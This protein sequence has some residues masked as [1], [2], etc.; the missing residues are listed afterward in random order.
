MAIIAPTI[1]EFDEPT[2][3]LIIRNLVKWIQ[4]D[5]VPQINDNDI[6]SATQTSDGLSFEINLVKGDGSTIHVG[7]ITLEDED[8]I[9]SGSFQFD[10]ETRMLSG[11][12]LKEDGTPINIPAVKIPE[13]TQVQTDYGI[14]TIQFTYEGNNLS[15]VIT[16]NDGTQTTS[17]T[18]V[19]AGGGGTGGNPYPTAISGTVGEDGNITLKIIMSE[20]NPVTATIDMSYFASAED[21]EDIQTQLTAIKITVSQDSTNVIKVSNAVNGNSADFTMDISVVDGELI[22]TAEDGTNQAITKQALPSGGVSV[23]EYGVVSAN[24]ILDTYYITVNSLIESNWGDNIGNKINPS[25][26]TTNTKLVIE[27]NILYIANDIYPADRDEVSKNNPWYSNVITGFDVTN[28]P[29]SI[30]VYVLVNSGAVAN[31]ANYNVM[32]LLF[33]LS[34]NKYIGLNTNPVSFA[35]AEKTIIG[36]WTQY[37]F[38]LT[39]NIGNNTR[40]WE[41]SNTHSMG[42]AVTVDAG[43]YKCCGIMHTYNMIPMLIST[44]PF[45]DIEMPDYAI[46]FSPDTA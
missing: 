42:Q 29:D 37:K 30:D 12:L 14:D 19:I 26:A 45:E 34:E 35:N 46:T 32:G 44:Q 33:E 18:V 25:K 40:Y 4:T 7:K 20:G 39:M 3:M 27:D 43:M 24:N 41:F 9:K 21:L 36:N 31:E 1:D 16:Q 22:L 11:T 10:D 38:A 17:N 6:V 2:V 23:K 13:S 15:C 5:L 28:V 8:N